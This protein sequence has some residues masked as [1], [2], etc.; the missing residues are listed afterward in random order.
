MGE[1]IPIIGVLLFLD[2]SWNKKFTQL[3]R[4]LVQDNDNTDGQAADAFKN[5]HYALGN[6]LYYP[7]DNVMVGGELQWG[8]RRELLGRVPRRRVQGAVLVQV[9]LL[10]QGRRIGP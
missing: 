2:H 4:L 7:A 3:D 1:P 10:V 9:Q 5:G 8:R 6:L